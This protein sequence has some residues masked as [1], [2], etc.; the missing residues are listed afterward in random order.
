MNAS[1]FS[2][3]LVRLYIS[4]YAPEPGR[5]VSDIPGTQ[6]D[7]TTEAPVALP[8]TEEPVATPPPTETPVATPPAPEIPA[9]SNGKTRQEKTSGLLGPTY[10]ENAN[11][12]LFDFSLYCNLVH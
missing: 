6:P 1:H 7:S 10:S 3:L 12:F 9:T 2:H 4:S 5:E 8:T 11:F